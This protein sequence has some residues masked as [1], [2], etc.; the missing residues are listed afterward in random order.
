[1]N[2]L[3]RFFPQ[4]NDSRWARLERMLLRRE[5]QIGGRL[6]G[7]VPKGHK[8][9]FFCLDE[10]TWI[11]HEEWLDQN[12]QR[13]S[14]TTRYE[15]RPNGILKTQNGRV[16]SELTRDEIRNL[17]KTAYLYCQRVNDEYQPL[18]QAA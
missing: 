6:F 9:E 12:R 16:Y 14:V 2:I 1:M 7:P 13:Q 8:R 5:A 3:P 11:W 15:V 4:G 10:H 18:L 17:Y